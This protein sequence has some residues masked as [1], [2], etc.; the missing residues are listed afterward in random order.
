MEILAAR[1]SRRFAGGRDGIFFGIQ[2]SQVPRAELFFPTGP[3]HQGRN[4]LFR[5]T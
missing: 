1:G 4:S 2:P 5:G 3:R